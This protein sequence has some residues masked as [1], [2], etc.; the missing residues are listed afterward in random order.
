MDAGLRF[1]LADPAWW[2]D[3]TAMDALTAEDQSGW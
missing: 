2:Q 3:L 1:W